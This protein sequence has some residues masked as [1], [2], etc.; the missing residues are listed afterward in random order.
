ML[1]RILSFLALA[2]LVV[3]GSA[4]A[5]SFSTDEGTFY[6]GSE[7]SFVFPASSQ[8]LPYTDPVSGITIDTM[9]DGF[10]G[11]SNIGGEDDLI[12][13]LPEGAE[14]IGFGLTFVSAGTITF[15]AF[16]G[17]TS[18]GSDSF[19]FTNGN[20]PEPQ[21]FVGLIA[22]AG[23]Q[24]TSVNIVGSVPTFGGAPSFNVDDLRYRPGAGGTGQ[25]PI[26][27]PSAALV[28]AVGTLVVGARVR[29]R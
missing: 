17:A 27:E 1:P 3:P 2:A 10:V 15:E 6:D 23:Q 28:F 11:T 9:T 5:L 19:D 13:L 20:P 26:P 8:N 22:M 7:V 21:D 25:E 4:L 29:R 24:I 14:R 18:L 16:D 12:I